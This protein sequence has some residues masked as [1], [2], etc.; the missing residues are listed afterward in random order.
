MG[1]VSSAYGLYV[2]NPHAEFGDYVAAV[3]TGMFLGGISGALMNPLASIT[4]GAGASG[5]GDMVGQFVAANSLNK[6]FEWDV[7]ET[8]IQATVGAGAAAIGTVLGTAIGGSYVTAGESAVL[9]TSISGWFQFA[10]NGLLPQK[11]GGYY[12]SAASS[13][14]HPV[15]Q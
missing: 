2:N 14:R 7:G 4:V 15:C 10:T 5:A 12:P 9:S 3:G 6:K 8:L 1:G 13:A 11:W